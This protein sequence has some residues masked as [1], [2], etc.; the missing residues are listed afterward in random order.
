MQQARVSNLHG[1]WSKVSTTSFTGPRVL[2]I[3]FIERIFLLQ[4]SR[5][6]LSVGGHRGL[7]SSFDPGTSPCLR[8]FADRPSSKGTRRTPRSTRHY[9]ESGTGNWR[10]ANSQRR[11]RHGDKRFS[12]LPRET[13]YPPAGFYFSKI[14]LIAREYSAVPFRPVPSPFSTVGVLVVADN[15]AA[16]R[17]WIVATRT[18]LG[19]N[20]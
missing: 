9:S 6:T 19:P 13:R 11:R 10:T 17:V 4:L 15:V 5:S 3:T 12:P 14:F 2:R 18:A 8:G 7:E 16:T 20:D 1:M